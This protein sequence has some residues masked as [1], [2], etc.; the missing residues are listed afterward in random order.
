MLVLMNTHTLV[1]IHE[2]YTHMEI[3]ICTYNY[4]FPKLYW[5]YLSSMFG[6]CLP[7]LYQFSLQPSQASA[8]SSAAL[9]ASVSLEARKHRVLMPLF[10]GPK[11]SDPFE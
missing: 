3:S 5:E 10:P 2:N 9:F 8:F 4:R 6:A 11:C 1:Y 7:L